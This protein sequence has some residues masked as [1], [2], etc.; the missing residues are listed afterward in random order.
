MKILI[1]RFSSIGDI[2][3]TTP[4]IRCIK[5]QVSEVEIHYLTSYSF[6]DIIEHNPYI[7]KK[8]Y[9]ENDLNSIVKSLRKENYDFIL[10]LHGS[11]KSWRIK[12]LLGKKSRTFNKLNFE[13]WLYVNFKWN[14][15]PPVHI[16]DRYL[17]PVR[18]LGVRNDGEGLDYFLAL[19]DEITIDQLPLTHIH[20]YIALV[21]GAKHYTKKLPIEKLLKLCSYLTYPIIVLGGS[22]DQPIGEQLTKSDS[23]K[24]VN[25]CGRYS[26]NQS[27]SFIKQ[28]TVVITHDT[29]LMH[30]AA[31]YNK[32][33]ISLW[34]NTVP[35]FGMY[36]YV[37]DLKSVKVG[38]RDLPCRPCSKIG[39]SRCP[40]GHFKCMELIDQKLVAEAVSKI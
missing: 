34:G 8:Y 4:V 18:W 29:G 16:V 26:L 24:I 28:S 9:L 25:G 30:I 32:K 3:L 35:E 10:D 31:A 33:I 14:I 27:A 13:K 6:R 39:F 11:R 40:Q 15:L 37:A 1:I 36:P 38:I 20:G 21:I 5:K 23:L 2:V 19:K 17:E 7:D 12:L 22:E